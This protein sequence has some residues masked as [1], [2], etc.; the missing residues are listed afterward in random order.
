MSSKISFEG[1]GEVVATFA[2]GEGVAAGQVVKVTEDGT[3]GACS[4]C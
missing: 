3:V 1:I 2:C 4:A